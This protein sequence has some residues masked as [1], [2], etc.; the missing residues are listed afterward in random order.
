MLPLIVIANAKLNLLMFLNE[1]EHIEWVWNVNPIQ[2]QPV[3][4]DCRETDPKGTKL[5]NPTRFR[6]IDPT[7]I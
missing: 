3:K 5:W 6:R 4:G 2:I 7:Q 1:Q